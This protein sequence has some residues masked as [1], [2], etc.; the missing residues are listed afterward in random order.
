MPSCFVTKCKIENTFFFVTLV[1]YI[2]FLSI[3]SVKCIFLQ[4]GRL[5]VEKNEIP[6]TKA[7]RHKD[8]EW[9]FHSSANSRCRMI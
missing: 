7:V 1:L 8:K 6:E 9:L 5:V 3:H 2:P 4:N